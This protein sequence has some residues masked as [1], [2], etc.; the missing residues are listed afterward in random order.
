MLPANSASSGVAARTSP[1]AGRNTSS[2]RNLTRSPSLVTNPLSP[3]LT[4]GSSLNFVS[5]YFPPGRRP[6]RMY[7]NTPGRWF[8]RLQE[9]CQAIHMGHSAA[10]GPAPNKQ[11]AATGLGVRPLLFDGPDGLRCGFCTAGNASRLPELAATSAQTKIEPELADRN[12]AQQWSISS[13]L[14]HL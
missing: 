6:E 7:A 9:R 2:I 3:A 12:S 13:S 14:L 5:T 1:G 10:G 4:L 8:P 11:K